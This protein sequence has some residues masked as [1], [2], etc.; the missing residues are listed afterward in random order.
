MPTLTQAVADY[1]DSITP[2]RPEKG[3]LG[4]FVDGSF[5]TTVSTDPSLAWVRNERNQTTT[6]KHHGR[7]NLATTEENLPLDLYYDESGDFAI[8][9]YDRDQGGAVLQTYPSATVPYYTQAEVDALIAGVGGSGSLITVGNYADSRPA[10]PNAGDTF[11]IKDGYWKEVYHDSAWNPWRDESQLTAPPTSGWSWLNQSTATVDESKGALYLEVPMST[12][13]QIRGRIR[14]VPS[15]PY[16][17]T[18]AFQ[19]IVSNT[20]RLYGLLWHDGTKVVDFGIGAV[21][22]FSQQYTNVT[23]TGST[24]FSIPVTDTGNSLLW[25]RI[26]DDGTNRIC[27]YSIDGKN[28][29]QVHSV[30]RTDFLTA[31]YVGFYIFASHSSQTQRSGALLLSWKEA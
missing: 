1:T 7:V 15:T 24:Y 27:S 9:G 14:T 6:A 10:S 31:T 19:G 28:W 17:I 2:G 20:V 3:F 22:R 12:G 26:A 21:S 8:L 18:A 4:A 25:L 29:I 30:T 23:T 13:T 11:L 5:Q 16:T